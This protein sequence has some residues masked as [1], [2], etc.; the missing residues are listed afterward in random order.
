MSFIMT[1]EQLNNP[2]IIDSLRA[3]GTQPMGAKPA[4]NISRLTKQIDKG[5]AEGREHYIKG[6]KQFVE[7]DENGEIKPAV[8]DTDAA[9]APYGRKMGDPIPGSYTLIEEKKKGFEKWVEDYMQNEFTINSYKIHMDDL[10]EVTVTPDQLSALDDVIMTKEEALEDIKK[11]N[12][13][14]VEEIRPH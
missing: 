9:G 11:T 2:G 4:W 1:L 13:E 7:L 14:N 6:L 10:A 3:L 12:A 8:F 5:I